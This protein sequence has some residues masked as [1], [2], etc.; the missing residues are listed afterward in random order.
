MQPSCR[1]ARRRRGA[2]PLLGELAVAAAS[3]SRSSCSRRGTRIGPALVAEVALDLADDR[4]GGVGRELDAALEVE[5]VDRLDQAD[6]ADLDEVV[7]GLAAVAEP[8]GQVLDQGQVQLDQ[9][10]AGGWSGGGRPGSRT[11]AREELAG[12]LAVDREPR[13]ADRSGRAVGGGSR[14]QSCRRRPA[15]PGCLARVTALALVVGA[16]SASVA[17]ADSTGQA[18][19]SRSGPPG[20]GRDGHRHLNRAG[21]EV[22]RQPSFEPSS[23]S[24]RTIAQ[25]SPTAMRRSSMASWQPSGNLTTCTANGTTPSSADAAGELHVCIKFPRSPLATVQAHRFG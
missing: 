11:A 17:R 3:A 13:A 24:G 10:V 19:L 8:A 12:A 16:A 25:A 22:K 15:T 20:G 5:A 1:P 18:K 6:R 23:A 14:M 9:R 2:G 4:R 21:R 7:V